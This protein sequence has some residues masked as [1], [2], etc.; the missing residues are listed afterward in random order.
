M[1]PAGMALGPHQMPPQGAKGLV[2]GLLGGF[3]GSPVVSAVLDESEAG[4]M[5]IE[6]LNEGSATAVHLAYAAEL[7][8]GVL[9]SHV[10]GDLAPGASARAQLETEL[11]AEAAFRC[12]W[13]CQD[14]KGRIRAWSYE[15]RGKRLRGSDA[16]SPDG[17]FSA[18]YR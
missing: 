11:A 8:N 3:R 1:I 2:A 17:V 14:A 4:S 13:W 9:T 6:F 5:R 12:V 18:L 10:V 7:S 15:G 16:T